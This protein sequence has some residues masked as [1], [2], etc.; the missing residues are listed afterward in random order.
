MRKRLL[1]AN[2]ST[3][4]ARPHKLERQR[5][6]TA[7]Y[8]RS[9]VDTIVA[10]LMWVIAWI[11]EIL[12][13]AFVA[14]GLPD[15]AGPA[16]VLSIIGLTAIVRILV[17]PLYN[18]QIRSSRQAQLIQPEVQKIQKKYKG[19]KDMVSRRR[20]QEEMQAVYRKHG[21]SPFATCLPMLVQMPILYALYRVISAFPS[22]SSG[23]RT[24]LGPFTKQLATDFENSTVFGAPLAT[25]FRTATSSNSHIVIGVLVLI[26]SVTMFY[27]QHQLMR[28]NMPESALDKSNPMYRTQQFM[29]YGMPLMYIFMGGILQ[30]AVLVYWVAGNIWNLC[31]QAWFIRNNPT[32]GSQAYKERQERL[33][34]KRK[35]KG[36]SKEEIENLEAEDAARAGVRVQPL[37]KERS[38]KA[39]A[40]AANRA[41][42][43]EADDAKE[44]DE[45]KETRG[46]DGLTE[47]ERARRRYE[48][49]QAERARSKAKAA[50]RKKR[51]QQN[52]KKRNF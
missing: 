43:N 3:R 16:W 34:E 30:V 6:I 8:E 42:Y 39:A 38:K 47:A 36:L 37:G 26:M 15:G 35:R 48:R 27:T 12:R 9:S 11:M 5:G 19:K 40:K 25:N 24:A 46:K 32:P 45:P 33:K 51:V 17:L 18:K 10:P 20:M 31:Q 7:E 23:R 44:G 13:R 21:T 1:R 4:F 28:K 22:I 52:Q 29:M 14:L 49:R 2:A 41:L 50:N